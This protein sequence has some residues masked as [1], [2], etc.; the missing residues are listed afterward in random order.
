MYQKIVRYCM[1]GESNYLY[2]QCFQ[3]NSDKLYK[4]FM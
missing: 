1:C 2:K 4:L 3:D